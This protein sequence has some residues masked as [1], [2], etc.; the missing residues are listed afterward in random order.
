[1]NT[2]KVLIVAGAA[3]VIGM[4]A[5]P[6]SLF[7]YKLLGFKLPIG[8][9]APGYQRDFRIFN[10]FAD[11]SANNNQTPDPNYPGALGAAM[12]FW[13]A[14]EVWDSNKGGGKNFDYDWQSDKPTGAGGLN[15]NIASALASGGFCSGGVL[16]YT[17]NPDS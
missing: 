17:E 1:M 7:A 4:T 15:D 3:L 10:N 2:R 11:S 14:G 16:A 9:S 5:L 8:T 6:G 13:K 12:A